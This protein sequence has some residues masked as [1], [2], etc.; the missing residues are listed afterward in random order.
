MRVAVGLAG[1]NLEEAWWIATS[2]GL[3][4]T[5][6][7]TGWLAVS[8]LGAVSAESCGRDSFEESAGFDQIGLVCLR[9]LTTLKPSEIVRR[10]VESPRVIPRL[11]NVVSVK[12]AVDRCGCHC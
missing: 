12:A 4:R 1:R 5:I 3:V 11:M 9:S 10:I 7:D 8:G 2:F 6:Q